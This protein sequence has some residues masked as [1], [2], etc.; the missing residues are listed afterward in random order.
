MKLKSKMKIAKIITFKN[1]PLLVLSVILLTILFSLFSL[2]LMLN[3]LDRDKIYANVLVD[4]DIN[5]LS[6]INYDK[7][8]EGILPYTNN[9]LQY[10]KNWLDKRN[11]NYEVPKYLVGNYAVNLMA[12]INSAKWENDAFVIPP[13]EGIWQKNSHVYLASLVY[14][15]VDFYEIDEASFNNLKH[16]GK[17]PKE[18][19]EVVISN[20]VAEI[21]SYYGYYNA[22]TGEDEIFPNDFEKIVNNELEI[23][24]GEISL[25]VVGIYFVENFNYEDVINFKFLYESSIGD[26]EFD[27][28]AVKTE[29]ISA[30]P[31]WSRL[32]HDMNKYYVSEKFFDNLDF[33]KV[34]NLS[35]FTEFTSY[36]LNGDNYNILQNATANKQINSDEIIIS[37]DTLDE[38]TNGDFSNYVLEVS[39]IEYN[40]I[41]D[42]TI[43]QAIADD[44][45]KKNNIIGEELYMRIADHGKIIHANGYADY[46]LKIIGVQERAVNYV[47]EEILRQYLRNIVKINHVEVMSDDY[48]VLYSLL[49]EF[50]S[51]D[52]ASEYWA[53]VPF[54]KEN[55]VFDAIEKT[56][57]IGTGV[58]ILLIVSISFGIWGMLH[59]VNKKILKVLREQGMRKKDGYKIWLWTWLFILG[60]VVL[61]WGP[62]IYFEKLIINNVISKELLKTYQIVDFNLYLVIFSLI[63]GL[64]LSL[65]GVLLSFRGP[66]SKNRL[67]KIK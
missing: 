32:L 53:E 10:I 51:D 61:L 58:L 26:G 55:A 7:E 60:F 39:G 47:S 59:L 31:N 27:A 22:T 25:K 46:K 42:E 1:K 24:L 6:I 16:I 18:A 62:A 33:N 35:Y 12:P 23:G 29:L 30:F 67:E 19:N 57:Q 15:E 20:F 11:I 54:E 64:L 38:M 2:S 5:Y 44:Y 28:G 52:A 13:K 48:D 36:Y 37:F 41:E 14:S 8:Y 43:L 34:S 3:K 4:N 9:D 65:I 40:L 56:A 45:M 63:I 50:K 66:Y 17:Y 49:K 21:L